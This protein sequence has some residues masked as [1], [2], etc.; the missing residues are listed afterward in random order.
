M[1]E[2]YF[3]Q[4]NGLLAVDV[5]AACGLLT[6]EQ[7][8]GL[9]RAAREKNVFRL[10]LT[11]RQT[12]AVLV[13]EEN[14]AQ[15]VTELAPLGLK[16]APFGKVVR[17]VK[18]C[19]GNADLCPRAIADALA[20]GLLIQEKYVGQEVPKDFKI[21]VAGCA[22]GCTDPQCADFGAR[23]AGKERFDVFIGGRGSTAQPIHGVPIAR[24][25]TAGQVIGLLDFV[26]ERYR[27]LA[28][29]SER[30]C[31]TLARVGGEHFQPP[32]EMLAPAEEEE[33]AE[34]AAFLQN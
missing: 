14:A 29:P 7:W 9:G 23:A 1:G 31:Q 10:K 8:L 20:L 13:P 4:K 34:F 18:A 28:Q 21:A 19:P 12:V 16:V 2:G 25:V 32:A 11:T 15:L 26:L 33:A 22:R 3:R 17:P 30:L 27:V 5:M 6:P 24:K